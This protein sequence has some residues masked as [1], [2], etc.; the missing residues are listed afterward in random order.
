MTIKFSSD[1]Q[2][3]VYQDAL[4]IRKQVFVIEQN[5][6]YQNELDQEADCTHIVYYVQT[7]EGEVPAGTIRTLRK[8]KHTVKFQRLAV[9]PQFRHQGTADALMDFAEKMVSSP[10]HFPGQSQD[11]ITKI[12]LDGQAYIKD[13]Y[14]N[15]GYEIQGDKFLEENIWHYLFIKQI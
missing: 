8:D 10:D 7:P 11:P 6:P 15:R 1:L 5:V 3:Q 4:E 12:V 9:L 14:S 13:F 2:S